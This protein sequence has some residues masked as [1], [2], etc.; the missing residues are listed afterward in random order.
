MKFTSKNPGLLKA[1][2]DAHE[3]EKA[4]AEARGS[5]ASALGAADAALEAYRAKQRATAIECLCASCNRPGNMSS[6]PWWKI[7]CLKPPLTEC[8]HYSREGCQGVS[9]P[10]P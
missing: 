5:M 7:C 10:A 2:V 3:A 4:W 1:A 8:E 6:V 9:S